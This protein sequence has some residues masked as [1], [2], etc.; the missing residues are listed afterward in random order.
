MS[1]HN[2]PLESVPQNEWN[3]IIG[4]IIKKYLPFC[5]DDA[6]ITS[7]DLEQEAW[8]GLLECC[9]RYDPEAGTRFT[10]FAYGS[11]RFHLCRFLTK[12]KLPQK[13]SHVDLDFELLEEHS[14]I[15]MDVENADVI[16]TIMAMVKGY[17]YSSLLIEHFIEGKSYRE[18][19]TKHGIS[20]GT[21]ANKIRALL[22]VLEERMSPHN[23]A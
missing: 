14:Y 16:R 18:L 23:V 17:Q 8:V 5:H 1:T 13:P 21:I 9:E 15:D 2:S 7:Q 10:T 4:S 3:K 22:E 12:R 20:R 11:I 19:G 6:L